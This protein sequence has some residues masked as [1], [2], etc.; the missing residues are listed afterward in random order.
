MPRSNDPPAGLSK[1]AKAIW[2]EIAGAYDLT[3][4]MCQLLEGGLEAWDR[5][6][7]A[8][9]ALA[10]HGGVTYITRHG[11]ILP[12][13]AVMIERDARTAYRQALKMMKLDEVAKKAPGG[14]I[15]TGHGQ[16]QAPEDPMDKFLRRKK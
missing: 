4:T 13:P 15:G 2:R 9:S 1:R 8:Q 3:P 7:Q 16:R 6:R 12:H 14:Q 10:E 11:Q 5:M